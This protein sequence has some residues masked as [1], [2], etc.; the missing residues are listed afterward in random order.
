MKTLVLAFVLMAGI[1]DDPFIPAEITPG[2]KVVRVVVT[3]TGWQTGSAS[4]VLSERAQVEKLYRALAGNRR[5]MWT[6]GYHWQVLFEYAD[7]RF[8]AI[9]INENC[10]TFER[11]PKETWSRLW[12]VLKRAREHP[13]HYAAAVTDAKPDLAPTLAR[14]GLPVRVHETTWL[15]M[16][17]KPWTDSRIKALR[18]A[19]AGRANVAAIPEY[20]SGS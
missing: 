13:S 1:P 7:G 20:D 16:T 15:V 19:C 12:A 6:C 10:E 17:K 4:L 8:E 11:E 9:D 3:K 18:D 5:V 2:R 14:F